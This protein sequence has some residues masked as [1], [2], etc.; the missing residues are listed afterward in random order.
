MGSKTLYHNLTKGWFNESDL[1]DAVENS[2]KGDVIKFTRVGNACVFDITQKDEDLEE[3]ES[4]DHVRESFR[5]AF[6]DFHKNR[7]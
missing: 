7:Y 1:G 4:F 2:D 3:I 5:E 6:L